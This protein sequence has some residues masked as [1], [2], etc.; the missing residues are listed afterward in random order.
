[1]DKLKAVGMSSEEEDDTEY[2]GQPMTLY[3]VKICV[4]RA[5]AIADYLRLVEKQTDAF[6]K[7]HCRIYKAL[8]VPTDDI[9]K[10][11]A[12]KGLP[13][14][15]YNGKWLNTLGPLQYEDLEVSEEAFALLVAATSRMV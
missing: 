5:R 6:E 9:G 3:R 7:Q 13:E 10:S 4:W 2:E 12:P 8:R 15:M 14:C 1:V 11:A